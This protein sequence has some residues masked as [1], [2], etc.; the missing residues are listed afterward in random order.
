MSLVRYRVSQNYRS[1]V[2]VVE[3]YFCDF[4]ELVLIIS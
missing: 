4:E 2:D 1:P 3:K